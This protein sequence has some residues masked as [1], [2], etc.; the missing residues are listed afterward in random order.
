MKSCGIALHSF[1]KAE[2]H[3]ICDLSQYFNAKNLFQLTNLP[4]RKN[5]LN[6]INRNFSNC[7]LSLGAALFAL[8]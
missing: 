5:S 6:S 7:I 8:Q 2:F 3:Q 4:N 1:I